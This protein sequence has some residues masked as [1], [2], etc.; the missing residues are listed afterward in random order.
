MLFGEVQ[1]RH[2]IDLAVIGERRKS[3]GHD[4]RRAGLPTKSAKH[5]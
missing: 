5:S 2:Y 3:F 4:P 1:M